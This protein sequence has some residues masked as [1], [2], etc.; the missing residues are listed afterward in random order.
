MRTVQA[1]KEEVG[2]DR[3]SVKSVYGRRR[4]DGKIECNNQYVEI[5]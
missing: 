2:Q 1:L 4:N 5:R 3:I